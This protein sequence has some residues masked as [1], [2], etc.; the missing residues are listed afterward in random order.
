MAARIAVRACAAL[1]ACS[2]GAAQAAPFGFFD[3]RSAAM[4]GAGVSA[5]TSGNASY[6]NPA[7][8]SLPR[9]DGSWSVQLPIVGV[10]V[11]DSQKLLDDVDRIEPAGDA[12]DTAI[13][14]FNAA[15]TQANAGPLATALENFRVEL[16]T[17]STK[18][19]DAGVFAAPLTV[20]VPG[21]TLGV[22]VYTAAR[23]D[24]GAQFIL[25]SNDDAY[26]TG[27]VSATQNYAASGSAA[28][29]L[30]LQAA[31][32]VNPDGTIKDPDLQSRVNL[33]GLLQ[34]EFGTS[35]S[36]QFDSLDGLAIGI[37][38]KIVWVRTLDY[39]VT[40][41][42]T[43]IDLDRGKT[44]HRTTN[45]DLGVAKEWGSLRAGLVGKNL[46]TKRYKT[47]LDNTIEVKPQFRAGVSHHTDW[48]TV[49]FDLDL[50]KN[51]P[52]GLDQATRYAAVGAEFDIALLKLRVGYR[53]DLA[54]NYPSVP[55]IGVGLSLF[56][57]HLD[58]AAARRGDE[59]AMLVAQL[60]FRY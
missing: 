9:P 28:D 19:V 50:T 52:A 20:G 60:G 41:Q 46:I 6:F 18:S 55:S 22:G 10:R 27:L 48:T 3:A 15:Q 29:L 43:T 24:L 1:L 17:M 13:T 5:A 23:G 34:A 26:L 14:N 25:D 56:G 7:L 4:G 33:R 57:L 8:L 2:V 58:I 59:E 11:V 51:D 42:Q 49:A 36:S 12:L 37:T 35:F 45:F 30:A 32:G 47:V 44:E 53:K 16:G 39:S 31:F 21:R 38:P 54:G 40:A